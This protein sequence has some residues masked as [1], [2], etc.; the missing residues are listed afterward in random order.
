MLPVGSTLLPIILASDQTYLTNFSGDKKL[1]PV[2]M[3]LGNI[4]SSIRNKSSY[5]AWIPIAMLPIPPKWVS[6]VL[7]YNDTQQELDALDVL[8]QLLWHVL[9]PLVDYIH[10]TELHQGMRIHCADEHICW[11]FP[12]LSS[13]TADHMENVN[14]HGIL[15]NHCAIC[16]CP[17]KD[18]GEL[19]REPTTPW[20]HIRYKRYFVRADYNS[21]HADGVKPVNNVL[22]HFTNIEPPSLVHVDLLHGIYLGI[23]DH[24]MTWVTSFL[25]DIRRMNVFSEIWQA[26]PPY[27]GF[28]APNRP[29]TQVSQWTGKEM[30]NLGRVILA[31]FAA[32]I[33]RTDDCT[34][35]TPA[36]LMDANKAI[37]AVRY[38]TDFHLLSQYQTHTLH[39]V[40]Y[41]RQSL[42]KLHANKRV[43][44]KYR[45]G[46][47][48]S[49]K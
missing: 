41:I 4:H 20:N 3:T 31:A 30:R 40:S 47:T 17:P 10:P 25:E 33:R 13:W 37:S 6:K 16:P 39:T 24:L 1:W 29:Y 43:F 42:E 7:G 14:I 44:L 19:P 11:C 26:I 9:R 15:T 8:H 5:H 34:K 48:T 2:Y 18:M 28:I 32:A 38:F 35:L 22:W 46:K 12:V 23:L 45:A 49:S 21:L 27:P 36:Q